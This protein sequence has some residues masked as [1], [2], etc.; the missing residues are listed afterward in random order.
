MIDKLTDIMKDTPPPPQIVVTSSTYL[1]HSHSINLITI[2]NEDDDNLKLK[3]ANG[4]LGSGKE[5]DRVSEKPKVINIDNNAKTTKNTEANPNSKVDSTF[6]KY[7]LSNP[8]P[9]RYSEFVIKSYGVEESINVTETGSVV[10]KRNEDG[11]K[12]INQYMVIKELGR[13]DY[14]M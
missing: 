1:S 4:A 9:R 13:Y 6:S 10:T 8:R 11:N 2:G 12:F 5:S 7:M 3:I 14:I